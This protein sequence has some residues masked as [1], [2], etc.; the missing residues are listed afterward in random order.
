MVRGTQMNNR[1]LIWM[2][3]LMLLITSG[4]ATTPAPVKEESL[5]PAGTFYPPLPNE[6]RLQFLSAITFEDD[7]AESNQGALDKFLFGEQRSGK[8]LNRIWDIGASNGKIFMV[9]RDM[10]KV[11]F[12]DLVNKNFNMLNDAGPGYLQDPVGIWVTE[13]EVYVTDKGRKQVVVFRHDNKFLKAYGSSDLFEKPMDVAIYG[14]SVYVIDMKKQQLFVLDKDTGKL[15]NTIGKPGHDDGQFWRPTHVTVDKAGNIYVDD[16]YNFRIQKFNPQGQFLMSIGKVGDAPGN[17]ARPKGIAVSAEGHLYVT[18][19]AFG[20][21]QIFDAN[22]GDLLLFF[23]GPGSGP[24]TLAFP[25][26]LAVD[27]ENVD[28]FK[29]LA[30]KDFQLEYLLYVGN[31]LGDH[32]LMVFGFGKWMGSTL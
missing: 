20:N 19:V 21:I 13:E 23:G 17:F 5:A 4:C 16:A 8:K 3:G 28:F 18:D 12:I 22:T 1:I 10:M 14:S 6:P 32:K 25:T 26:G 11:I 24:G 27:E 15:V 30:N 9:D 2:T 29:G 7:I 31:F